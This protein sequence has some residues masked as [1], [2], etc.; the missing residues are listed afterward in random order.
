MNENIKEIWNTSKSTTKKRQLNL[1]EE[2][3]LA[4]TFDYNS[5]KNVDREIK[6]ALFKFLASVNRQL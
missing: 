4:P 5:S 6:E 2:L 3:L 1:S